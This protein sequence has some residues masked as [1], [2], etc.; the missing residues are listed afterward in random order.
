MDNVLSF[1]DNFLYRPDVLFFWIVYD[2]YSNHYNFNDIKQYLIKPN[3]INGAKEM[4]NM[5]KNIHR[6]SNQDMYNITGFNLNQTEPTKVV[7]IYC[8]K[9]P[10]VNRKSHIKY[11]TEHADKINFE[12]INIEK[13]KIGHCSDLVTD[14]YL[15]DIFAAIIM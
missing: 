12:I 7:N 5:I 1:Q 9:D 11:V 14:C 8:E 10:F 4:V 3:I 15:K 2:I 13:N 6:F